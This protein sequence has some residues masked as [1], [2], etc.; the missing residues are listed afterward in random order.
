MKPLTSQK[1]NTYYTYILECKD[2]SF[3]TGIAT[4]VSRR[5]KE[6]KAGK[7][8]N[9]TRSHG[10]TRIVYTEVC[11]NRSTALK[12]EIEIK[13]LRRSAKRDLIMGKIVT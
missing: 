12:R 13:R 3:Y 9:Y 11:K 2:G 1:S 10:V 5:F 6:H 8:G 7:G 4:N